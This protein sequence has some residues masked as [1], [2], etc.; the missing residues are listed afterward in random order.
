M[1]SVVTCMIKE[2]ARLQPQAFFVKRKEKKIM[3]K[4]VPKAEG[5]TY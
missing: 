5:S 1:D 2:F 4:I 3:S